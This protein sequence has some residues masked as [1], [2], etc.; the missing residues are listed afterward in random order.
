MPKHKIL[1]TQAT[2]QDLTDMIEY[3]SFGNPSAALQLADDIERQIYQLED[4]LLWQAE[5]HL[6]TDFSPHPQPSVK[7]IRSCP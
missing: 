3:I 7:R 2:I 1:I 4:F 5:R 6:T